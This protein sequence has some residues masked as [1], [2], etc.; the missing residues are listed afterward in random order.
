MTTKP[1]AGS[2]GPETS[3]PEGDGL[4][5]PQMRLPT[6]A[7]AFRR[8]KWIVLLALVLLV[9]ALDQWSKDWA[10]Q[11]L[12]LDHGGRV[13]VIADYFALSYVRNPG[14]AWGFLARS[15]ES[16][17]QPF[18]VAIS[19]VAMIFI[20][21]LHFRLEP[22]QYLLLV[23]LSLVLG[24]AV[25]NFIDRLRFRFVVDFIELHYQNRFKWPTF[26]VADIAITLG[27]ILLLA[28]MLFGPH[29]RRRRDSSAGGPAASI[30]AAE[31]GL[32][33]ERAR[34]AEED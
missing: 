1:R 32:P 17:R 16:F 28:E 26:N 19:V 33:K 8:T 21:Y 5:S 13:T 20:L 29:L 34:G 27:V 11:A 30:P 25:G 10:H 23:A 15:S 24:G 4:P 7:A 2:G 31:D 6:G 12:R 3:S 14:A 9:M 18:F 22:G